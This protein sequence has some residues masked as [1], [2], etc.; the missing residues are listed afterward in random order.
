MRDQVVV[1]A[2]FEMLAWLLTDHKGFWEKWS[3][4]NQKTTVSASN[5]SEFDF[6]VALCVLGWVVGRIML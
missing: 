6:F 4:S 5:V 3:Q 1:T 2:N